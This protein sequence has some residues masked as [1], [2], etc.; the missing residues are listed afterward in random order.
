MSSGRL[1]AWL[2][3]YRLGLRDALQ[4]AVGQGYR[5]V[6]ANAARG[7]L[8]AREFSRSARRHLRKYLQDL[9]LQLDALSADYPGLGLADPRHADARINHLK[10]V[11]ELCADLHV[12]RAAVSLSGFDDQRTAPLAR[13]LLGIVADLSDRCGVTTSVL[14]PA[15]TPESS[16]RL[17]RSVGCAGLR[18]ALDTAHLSPTLAA[19]GQYADLVGVV[20]LRDIHRR[21]EHV[22]E[23]PFGQGEVDFPSLLAGLDAGGSDASLVVRRDAEAGVDALREAREYMLALL[24]RLPGR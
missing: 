7:E 3:S 11:L 24:G 2:D 10:H 19:A 23:V 17:V 1:S 15:A 21:G 18:L 20:Y 22:E 5:F 4:C 6:Q 16:A 12:R 9:G 8:E 14:D 13:E